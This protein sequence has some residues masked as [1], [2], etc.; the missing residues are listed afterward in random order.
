MQCMKFKDHLKNLKNLNKKKK[1]GPSKNFNKNS[2][3]L[4]N[5]KQFQKPQS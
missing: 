5:L 3:V 2:K 1:K 4:K